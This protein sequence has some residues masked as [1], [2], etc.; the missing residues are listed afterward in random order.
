MVRLW[1]NEMPPNMIMAWSSGLKDLERRLR[2]TVGSSTM[3]VAS[4]CSGSDIF[5]HC[6]QSLSEWWRAQYDVDIRFEHVLA[7]ERDPAKREFL[8]NQHT[9]R[10]LMEDMAS[11]AD[12]RA[13]NLLTKKQEYVP[14]AMMFVCGFSCT[15][16][17]R[18]NQHSSANRGCVQRNEGASG[19]TFG[20]CLEYISNSRPWISIL[21]NVV[22]LT[23]TD[24]NV[25]TSDEDWILES[26]T[27]LGFLAYSYRVNSV[28]FGSV[29]ERNRLYFLVLDAPNDSPEASAKL[30]QIQRTLGTLKL[31][32]GDFN[33]ICMSPSVVE[34]YTGDAPGRTKIK[35]AR[36]SDA[37]MDKHREIF[38]AL[39]VPWPPVLPQDFMATF[40]D[41]GPRAMELVYIAHTRFP[42]PSVATWEFLDA[43]PTLER[44]LQWPPPPNKDVRNPWRAICGTLT[45]M[46]KL[47]VR[48]LSPAGDLELRPAHC[49]ESMRMMGWDLLHYRQPIFTERV[50]PDVL[51]SLAGNAFSA[52]AITPLA[53]C[54]LGIGGAVLGTGHGRPAATTTDGGAG[55][56]MPSQC[57]PRAVEPFCTGLA[58]PA[59]CRKVLQH[60]CVCASCCMPPASCGVLAR[61]ASVVLLSGDNRC[62][63][64][65]ARLLHKSIRGVLCFVQVAELLSCVCHQQGSSRAGAP[66]NLQG[67]FAAATLFSREP[68]AACLMS[69]MASEGVSHVTLGACA[70]LQVPLV[71]E[72]GRIGAL[73]SAHTHIAPLPPARLSDPC[74]VV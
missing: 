44:V 31:G 11:L 69:S 43:N 12:A 72:S 14:H 63:L 7:V 67:C 40:S 36:E 25:T 62:H 60:I 47:V 52:F 74:S 55:I 71:C 19:Q 37:W 68:Q 66:C 59:A 58:G 26:F 65:S 15:S 73:T 3:P 61:S 4:A 10:F 32:P 42:P 64:S 20:K 70:G 48:R 51:V 5:S 16:R 34:L 30:N 29:C 22:E 53:L 18:L 56:R 23:E 21:E 2:S 9:I 50:T 33:D 28:D 45:G 49:L 1:H 54:A 41:F 46:T 17:S 8:T 27:K 6:L 13:T 35:R 38:G 57:A 39:E 24:E